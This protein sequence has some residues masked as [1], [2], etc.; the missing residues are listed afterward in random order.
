MA[1]CNASSIVEGRNVRPVVLSWIA[2]G[3]RPLSTAASATMGFGATGCPHCAANA[4][5]VAAVNGIIGRSLL[6]ARANHQCGNNDFHGVY[7]APVR[8]LMSY[9][10]RP[11]PRGLT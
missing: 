2:S 10:V 8:H 7:L 3:S 11:K 5:T 4:N 9:E 6:V 1:I